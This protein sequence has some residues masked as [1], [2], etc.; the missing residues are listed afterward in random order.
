MVECDGEPVKSAKRSFG[1]AVRRAGLGE[2]VDD[3]TGTDRTRFVT[4][5]TPHVAHHTA[6]VWMV[7]D[8]IQMAKVRNISGI[9]TRA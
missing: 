8:G 4:D 6:A 5:V 2:W 9:P 1:S 7:G 3:E